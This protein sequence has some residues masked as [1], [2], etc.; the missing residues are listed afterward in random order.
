MGYNDVSTFED[1]EI[2]ETVCGILDIL[3]Y[4]NTA[5]V[6]KALSMLE[7]STHDY[8]EVI[9]RFMRIVELDI[10]NWENLLI[11]EE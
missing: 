5:K 9:R 8:N 10:D 11:D 4:G 1:N 7:L 6:D 3:K 2:L